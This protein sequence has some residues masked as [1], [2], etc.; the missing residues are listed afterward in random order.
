MELSCPSFEN[1]KEISKKY[2]YNNENFS[3][4]LKISSIPS[5]TK[6]LVLIM[7]DPDAMKAVGKIWT[8]WLLWNISPNIREIAE[9]QIPIGSTQ[10]KNDFGEIG[11]GGPA[12][13][14]KQ[15][16]YFFKIYA[17]NKILDNDQNYTKIEL[18]GLIQSSIIDE[19]KL[20]GTY[21]PDK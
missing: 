3:P 5:G 16:T 8:H 6:S 2:G 13:P 19:S 15:H 21:T 18:E 9:N 1:G 11:Y 20:T 14:D 4:P 17:L 10:G 7:D 12:P